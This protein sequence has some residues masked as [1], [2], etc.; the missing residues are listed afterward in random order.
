MDSAYEW[1]QFYNTE[2][3]Q[4]G[5]ATMLAM[6]DAAQPLDLEAGGAIVIPHTRFEITGSQIAAAV[7]TV[8]ES[9][10]D[11][12]LALGVLHGARRSD[13][14]E[15]ARAK[16]GDPEAINALR[17]V[18]EEDGLAA[19][20]FSLDAFVQLLTLAAERQGRPIDVVRRYPF[21]VGENPAS[22]PGVEGLQEMVDDGAL[23]VATTDPM[24]H[25]RAYGMPVPDCL[26]PLLASTRAVAGD[27]IGEQLDALSD[28]R[29]AE[30]ARLVGRDRSDF[31]DTGPVMAHLLGS[32]FDW[33]ICD[34]DLVDYSVVLDSPGPSWVAGALIVTSNH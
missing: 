26:D 15:V 30:F 33:K 3:D 29:F 32:G 21:L 22:L 7:S 20:E 24:H 18:H 16:A 27:A 25:G 34:L 28:H 8:L 10:T 19:E 5:A 6:V 4:I 11:R 2:R 17:G 1:K 12:V 13:Q 23:L 31:R 14:R 9:G